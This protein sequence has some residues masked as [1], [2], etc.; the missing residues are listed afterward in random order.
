[1][2][3]Q[4]QDIAVNILIC[5][6][7]KHEEVSTIDFLKNVANSTQ[8]DVYCHIYQTTDEKTLLPQFKDFMIKTDGTIEYDNYFAKQIS[9]HAKTFNLNKE[10]PDEMSYL[11]FVTSKYSECLDICSHLFEV[12]FFDSA[13]SVE[14]DDVEEEEEEEEEEE[15]TYYMPRGNFYT[16][17][18]VVLAY[19]YSA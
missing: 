4:P 16:S 9:E 12:E 17:D 14:I 18:A 7:Y 2:S 1:M 15:V 8:H 10:S 5:Y 19:R 3:V 13:I 6:G 11:M